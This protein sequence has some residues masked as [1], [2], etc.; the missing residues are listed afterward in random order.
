MASRTDCDAAVSGLVDKLAEVNPELRRR[1]VVERTVSCRVAD[2]GVTYSGRLCDDGICDVS[3]SAEAKAQ[4]RL[5][6]DSDDLLALV[7]GRLGVST[8]W[9]VG[10]LRVQANP[11]DLLKLRTLL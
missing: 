8:A 11:L 6:L 10:R 3:T 5:T 7:E 9:A 2:L 4:V 1:Y